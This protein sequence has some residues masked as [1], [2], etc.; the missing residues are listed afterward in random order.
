M[1]SALVK[2]WNSIVN[3]DDYVFHLGD[4]CF[5]SKSSWSYLLDHLNGKKYLAAGNHDKNITP[6]KFIDV[7]HRFNIR[8]LGD[9]E[10]ASDGQRITVDHYAM[11]TWYQSHRG[12]WQLFGHCI[13]LN[14]EILTHSGWK[15]RENINKFDKILTL[16]TQ[17]N[18]LEYNNINNIFDYNY[19]GKVYSYHGKSVDFRVTEEHNL[20]EI[21]RNKKNTYRYY[22]AYEFTNIE[23]RKFVKSGVLHQSGVD[24]SDDEIRLIVQIAT[25]GNLCNSNLCRLKVSKNRKIK[26][27]KFLLEKL[28]LE[29]SS[30]KQKDESVSFNFTIPLKFLKLRLKPISEIILKFN[31]QQFDVLVDE[32]SKS[33]GYKNNNTDR[34]SVV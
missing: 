33:D 1:D 7:Q 6:D 15:K 11:L 13:D 8:I 28:N 23:R 29:Y 27:V 18:N 2:N 21:L 22:K 24:L 26:N 32:Y 3:V 19:V 17:T 30:L 9:P 12:A 5:G 20:I 31:E 4:F 16:N 14:S 10:I 25:D 34:K